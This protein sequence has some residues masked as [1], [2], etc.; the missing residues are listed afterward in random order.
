MRAKMDIAK[1]PLQPMSLA[2]RSGQPWP[3]CMTNAVQVDGRPQ[4]TLG[5]VHVAAVG[6][7]AQTK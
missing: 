7:D 4:V 2:R 3:E 6:C 1:M 5:T